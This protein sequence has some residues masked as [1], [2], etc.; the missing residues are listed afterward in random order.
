MIS[1]KTMKLAST[2]FAMG[3]L[4]LVP[5]AYADKIKHPIAVFA[6]LDKITGRIIAFDVSIDE[7][8]QF[9]S[10]QITPRVCYTRPQTEAPLTEGFV[11][12]DEVQTNKQ[13]KRIFSGWMFAA[14][15]GLHGV[16]HAVYDVWITDCKGGVEVIPAPVSAAPNPD[17]PPPPNATPAPAP[18]SPPPAKPRPRRTI[19]P[20]PPADPELQ[21]PAMRDPSMQDQN[22]LGAPIEVA[23]PPGARRSRHPKP[24]A[25]D[26]AEPDN[27]LWPTTRQRLP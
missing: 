6:G 7:T 13:Y 17:A 25:P 12:V 18:D 16:E 8:V 2:A 26:T 21:D 27:S 9:G 3:F 20:K 22:G 1:T 4:A 24:D 5:M 23:P 19:N 15:P 10:L 14:S 11:E